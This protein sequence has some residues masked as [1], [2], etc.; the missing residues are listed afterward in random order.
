MS[1]KRSR[2]KEQEARRRKTGKE[3]EKSNRR[4]RVE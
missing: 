1:V 2:G 3:T 4:E